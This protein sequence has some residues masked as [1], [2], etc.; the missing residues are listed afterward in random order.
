MARSG[1]VFPLVLIVILAIGL[2]GVLAAG[3]R[4]LL[5]DRWGPPAPEI[6]DP[7][8]P[9]YPQYVIERVR[10]ALGSRGL[11]ALAVSKYQLRPGGLP[12]SLEDLI[13]RPANLP[14]D[15]VWDGPYISTKG[16]LTDPWGNAYRYRSP[17]Q[18]NPD[19][20]DLW[21]IGPDGQDAT[22]DDIGNWTLP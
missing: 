18:H 11:L 13:R 2:M 19:G 4:Y 3:T 12:N 9:D 21:S 8:V 20:Y 1:P 6:V 15:K 7:T 10:R 22:D 5:R 14:P 17:G 16:L